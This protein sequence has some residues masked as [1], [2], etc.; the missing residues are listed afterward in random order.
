M[1]R[2]GRLLV[3]LAL[4]AGTLAWLVQLGRRPWLS[5]E[6]SDLRNWAETTPT[7]DA[8]AAVVWLVALTCAIWVALTTLLYLT[9]LVSR[10]PA[11]IRSVSWMT[12]PVIR[13]AT[14]GALAACLV[15]ATTL[16]VPAAALSPPPVV[17]VVDEDGT[18]LPPGITVPDA[19][20]VPPLPSLPVDQTEQPPL[21]I[22]SPASTLIAGDDTGQVQDQRSDPVHV[23]VQT[24]DNLWSISRRQLTI[25]FG[26]PPGNEQ[27]A[28]YWRRVIEINRHSLI[29][30]NPDLIYPGEVLTMPATD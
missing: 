1:H 18:L 26:S 21:R 11:F 17:V 2:H 5:I 23:T 25:E 16:P 20:R 27:I 19:A 14:E 28:R 30:G 7:E 4:E 3:V 24:G 12:L 9:A 10:V 6:W 13:R 22:E 15:T 29:S 8:L